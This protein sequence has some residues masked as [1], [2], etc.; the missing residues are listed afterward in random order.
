MSEHLKKSEQDI[1]ANKEVLVNHEVQPPIAEKKI[2]QHEK[3]DIE[4]TRRQV[5]QLT[6]AS[7]E[8]NAD[9]PD[10]PGISTNNV[11][12]ANMEPAAVVLNRTLRAVRRNLTPSEKVFSKFIHNPII[13]NVSELT[14]KTLARPYALLSGGIVAIIGSAG[15]LY[16]THHLGY[17][18]NYFVPLLLFAGGLVA[19]IIVELSYKTIS[20]SRKTPRL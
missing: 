20:R 1:N 8:K 5:E 11:L 10:R 7:L 3:L 12:Q 13:N 15:Y 4:K 16:Y 9:E 14:S 19:G 18:Y 6:K 17:K 2:A